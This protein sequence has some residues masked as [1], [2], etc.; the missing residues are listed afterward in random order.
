MAAWRENWVGSR[1][2]RCMPWGWWQASSVVVSFGGLAPRTCLLS[3]FIHLTAIHSFRN[4]RDRIIYSWQLRLFMSFQ[5]TGLTRPASHHPLSPFTIRVG[6]SGP[7]NLP[8]DIGDAHF[9]SGL[10]IIVEPFPVPQLNTIEFGSRINPIGQPLALSS[11]K[12]V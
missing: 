7:S 2:S 5:A 6:K 9:V 3:N 12:Y 10:L 8:L 4:S 1:S 11:D